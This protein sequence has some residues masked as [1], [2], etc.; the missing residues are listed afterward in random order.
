MF[1]SGGL[2]LTGGISDI[3]SLADCLLGMYDGRAGPQI[4][5]KYDQVR[6]AK[7]HSFTDPVSTS[8]LRRVRSN[9]DTILETDPFLQE[10]VLMEQDPNTTV[11]LQA[12]RLLSW[13]VGVG[14]TCTNICSR[15][16]NLLGT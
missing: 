10:L 7:Y 4:L 2:G 16:L 1:P 11:Q 6:R 14:E 15:N 13:I 3:G 5:D 9:G 8:N 12:V